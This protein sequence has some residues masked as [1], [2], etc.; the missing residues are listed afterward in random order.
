MK[1]MSGL[2]VAVAILMAAMGPALV[3][4]A[5]KPMVAGQQDPVQQDP[6]QQQKH[7]AEVAM[8]VQP[9]NEALEGQEA[10]QNVTLQL[11][12]ADAQIVKGKPYSADTST[13][14]V[15]TLADGNRI[16]HR[17]VSKF[18]RDSDGRTRR[19]QTFGNVDPEHPSAHEVKVFVDD[20]AN[21]TAFVMDPGSKS[22]DKVQ[23]SPKFLD[24]RNAEF[25]DERNAKDEAKRSMMTIESDGEEGAQ[26]A[27]GRMMIKFRDEHS[28]NL[29]AIV[30]DEKRD[31]VKED[32]GNRTIEGVD[33]TGTRQ[34]ITIPA[35][36]V[37]NEKPISIVT[38]TWF[39]P[40]IAAVV[41]SA[42]DDP[43][44]GKTT[45]QLTNVQLSEPA[46]ALF[47][48]PANFKVNVR[49]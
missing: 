38:E 47:E 39:A 42:T 17:T 33:C 21:G 13:E 25:L 34:T 2:R 40:A 14:T 12:A 44:Y 36:A 4:Q 32:L 10:Q 35:G 22:A 3:G 30:S 26:G 20:P 49:K 43:R 41:E 5:E 7:A 28:G 29:A 9:D 37:G 19:E 31:V 15:Q 6:G 1:T 45:Y 27:P 46:R 11:I 16:V 48:P 18:Y 24:E 8:V 23:R